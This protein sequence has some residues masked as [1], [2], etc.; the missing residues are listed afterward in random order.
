M[1]FKTSVS[2]VARLEL[3]SPPGY[4]CLWQP[5]RGL[6][7]CAASRRDGPS[8]SILNEKTLKVNRGSFKEKIEF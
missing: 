8:G 1:Q 2:V 5:K 4:G 7:V 3:Q 6:Y